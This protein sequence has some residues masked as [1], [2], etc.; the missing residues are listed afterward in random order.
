MKKKIPLQILEILEPFV[1]MKGELFETLPPK[2]FLLRFVDKED[3]SDFY[4]NVEQYKMENGFQLIIDWK[5]SSKQNVANSRVSIKAQDLSTFFSNWL[6]LLEGYENVDTVFDDPIIKAFTDEYFADFE[7]IDDDAETKPF[8]TKQIIQLNSH[9]ENIQKKIGNFQTEENK[10]EI[11]EIINDVTELQ[12]NLTK[13]SKKWVVCK[14]SRIWAKI[15]K[16]GPKLMKEFLN[17][18]RKRA[19]QEGVKFI[20]E[21]SV[22][23]I[24]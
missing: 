15:T 14:L 20:L 16:Q 13:K 8:S 17:E 7:I 22:D 6:E 9:L 18:A 5:P 1:N 24:G 19:I 11:L 2:G 21:K 4:F 3:K 23:Y 12:N 10:E